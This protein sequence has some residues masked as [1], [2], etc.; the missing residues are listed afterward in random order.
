MTR[1]RFDQFSKQFL[2]EVL[3]PSSIVE[4]SREVP[5]EPLLI[6]LWVTPAPERAQQRQNLG[7]LGRMVASPCALEPYRNAPSPEE[8]NRCILK[9][10]WVTA[11]SYRQAKRAGNRL[12]GTEL[13]Q[14][15]LFTPTASPALLESLGAKSQVSWPDGV[16]FSPDSLKIG[17]VVLHQLPVVEETLWLRLLGKGRTQERAISEVI[18]LPVEDARRRP[19]LKLLAT[20]K[21]N[22]ESSELIDTEEEQLIMALSQAYLEWERE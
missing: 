4:I 6:D 18:A 1:N 8:V 7:L 20:W 10:A 22:I 5:A 19:I 13:P 17:I 11:E 12:S 9:A 3:T 15:W 21:I 16:Y 2:E 14:L